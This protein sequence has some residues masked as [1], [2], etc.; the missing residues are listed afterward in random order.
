MAI[1]TPPRRVTYSHPSMPQLPTMTG[2]VAVDEWGGC[3][4]FFPDQC[5]HSPL[6]SLYGY[7]PEGGLYLDGATV[8]PL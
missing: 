1:P 8:T 4:T 5:H 6:L 2:V 3:E 7:E